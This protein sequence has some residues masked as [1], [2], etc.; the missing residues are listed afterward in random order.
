METKHPEQPEHKNHPG[1][2]RAI[3]GLHVAKDAL[4]ELANALEKDSDCLGSD[5]ERVNLLYDAD[6]LLWAV[7]LQLSVLNCQAYSFQETT[8]GHVRQLQEMGLLSSKTAKRLQRCY[9]DEDLRPEATAAEEP[10]AIVVPAPPAGQPP[11]VRDKFRWQ[12]EV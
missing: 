8:R 11:S 10:A 7:D 1:H 5:Q 6:G 4:V 12:W 9:L 2:E 3:V